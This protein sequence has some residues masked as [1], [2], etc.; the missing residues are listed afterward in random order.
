MTRLLHR[1]LRRALA[2]GS[3]ALTAGL[4]PLAA[5]AARTFNLPPGDAAQTL[6]QFSTQAGREIV[7]APAAVSGA[8]TNAVKGDLDPKTALDALLAGT[9]L[10]ATQDAKTGAFAVR[11]D[12][13]P[14]APRAAQTESRPAKTDA[15]NLVLE[16]F[17]VTERRVDGIVNKSLIPTD[18]NSPLYLDVIGRLEIERLG[19]TSFEELLR[20]IPQT[21]SAANAFQNAPNNANS[22]NVGANVSVVGLRGFANAQTL[23]LIN[24]RAQPRTGSFSVNGTDLSRIPVAAIERVEILPLAASAMHGGGALAGAINIILR[25]EYN[26]KELTTYVGTSWDGGATE[27]R[28]SY[29]DGRSFELFGRKTKL[30]LLLDYSTREPLYQSDRNYLKR[31][32]EKYGPNTPVRSAAGVSA[33]ELFT[34]NT[35]AGSPPTILVGNAPNSAVNDLGIPGAAGLRWVQVPAGTTAAQSTALTPASFTSVAGQYTPGNRFAGQTIYQPRDNYSGSIQFEHELTKTL[36]VY[37]EVGAVWYRS[38][39][40]YPQALI[41]NLTNVDPLNPFRTNVTPG[42]V[43]RPVRI[44]YSTPDIPDP[45]QLEERHTL[46]GLL[47]IKGQFLSDWE[48]SLDGNYDA[49][50][51]S[52]RANNRLALMPTLLGLNGL[53]GTDGVTGLPRVPAPLDV[54]RAAYPVLAD[55]NRFPVPASD[56]DTYWSSVRFV[57]TDIENLIGIGRVTGPI[58]QLPAGPIEVGLMGEFTKFAFFSSTSLDHADGLM[59]LASGFPW[60][61]SRSFTDVD[62]NTLAG[63]F[64]LKMPVFN[65]KWRPRFLP[66]KS[67]E[68]NF[69]T[70]REEFTSAYVSPGTVDLNESTEHGSSFMAGTKVQILPDVAV[71][72]SFSTGLYPPD[73]NDFGQTQTL[74]LN[75]IAADPK[76]G[77]TSQPTGT[78][79][80]LVGGNPFVLSETSTSNNVGL[81]F[82]PRFLKGLTLNVD[83]WKISK[84]DGIVTVAAAQIIAREADYPGRVVRDPLTP[85]DAA[86]GYTGGLITYVNQ[87]TTNVSRINTEG[88]DVQLRYDLQTASIGRFLFNVN[89]SFTNMFETKATAVST[90]INTAGVTGPRRWRGRAATTWSKGPFDVTLSGRYSGH[91]FGATTSPSP[92]LPNAFPYDGGRIPAFARYDLQVSYTSR[93]SNT[94]PGL[95]RL[96]GGTKFTLGCQNILNDEPSMVSNGTGY[97]NTDDDPRQRFMYLSVKKSF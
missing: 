93:W 74:S 53:T 68:L 43:G 88:I 38:E 66:L 67:M 10:V 57:P 51:S 84:D 8:K 35:F 86:R 47:G 89:S 62:R 32:L 92:A 78:Y 11:R 71:R 70:R 96:L 7:F 23:I 73:W 2:L 87:T 42:F 90:F 72:Y 46:R 50:H 79:N 95:K 24:G 34:L 63:A 76:R 9:G 65:N 28:V 20:Y 30:T 4:I 64:E 14:N 6:K 75:A 45:V 5:E 85:D 69:S 17:E 59:L 61:A 27:Y 55:H 56:I 1:L 48:W 49:Y 31:A 18:E 44:F 12:S 33:F 52:S 19:V 13:G 94:D 39:Y 54:R 37:A 83:Y 40:S 16:K 3:I 82:T 60:T 77:N 22:A 58:Y 36:K 25:K 97:Y 41:L 21:S 91:Y 15:G 26:A 81:I 29:L 80:W